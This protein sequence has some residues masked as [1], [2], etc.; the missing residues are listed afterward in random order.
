[1]ACHRIEES[2]ATYVCLPASSGFIMF[3]CAEQQV[4]KEGWQCSECV[5]GDRQMLG[6]TLVAVGRPGSDL[7]ITLNFG[8]LTGQSAA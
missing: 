8:K 4:Q 3:L 1:M 7:I 5:L 2:C 6:S